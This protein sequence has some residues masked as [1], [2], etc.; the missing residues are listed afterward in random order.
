MKV[1][2][3]ATTNHWCSSTKSNLPS[4]RY[5][6]L[7]PKY[8]ILHSFYHQFFAIKLEFSD[9][10]S[11]EAQG[12]LLRRLIAACDD[13]ER[14]SAFSDVWSLLFNDDDPVAVQLFQD[15]WQQFL[16][17]VA[18][19]RPERLLPVVKQHG[20]PVAE[21]SSLKIFSALTDNAANYTTAIKFGLM[22]GGVDIQ[23]KAIGL[24]RDSASHVTIDKE[25]AIAVIEH[26]AL[27]SLSDLVVFDEVLVAVSKL[28]QTSPVFGA[29]I[30]QLV[31]AKL[32][33]E[34]GAVLLRA[35]G[36][37]DVMFSIAHAD[38]LLARFLSH[39]TAGK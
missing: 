39:H 2:W 6:N 31:S 5:G 38:A 1:C 30:H 22:Y 7:I 26:Q 37:S 21:Q 12:N 19:V 17:H 34:A 27:G 3:Q 10:A 11:V 23:A 4:R 15:H 32:W 24:L 25:M 16:L 8:G 33:L 36:V 9:I 14:I 20:D 28:P 18:S 13:Q 35:G 29:A